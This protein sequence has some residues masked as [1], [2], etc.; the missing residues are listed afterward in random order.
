M[1]LV[2]VTELENYRALLYEIRDLAIGAAM[3]AG[4]VSSNQKDS[5]FN[6][7]MYSVISRNADI[8]LSLFEIIEF[9][10]E[11]EKKLKHEYMVVRA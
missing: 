9:I 11:V 7:A 2:K 8:I 5:A 4:N 1:E 6:A 3:Y 10:P